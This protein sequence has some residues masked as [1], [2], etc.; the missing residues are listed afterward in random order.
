M[1]MMS[2]NSHFPL[3]AANSSLLG[4]MVYAD[5]AAGE[6]LVHR[7]RGSSVGNPTAL[8]VGSIL[9]RRTAG[10]GHHT[11]HSSSLANNE[12]LARLVSNALQ[13]AITLADTHKLTTGAQEG[14]GEEE[15]EHT[16][17]TN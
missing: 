15:K 14:G 4:T 13:E 3:S 8:L 1:M 16:L 10:R 9:S 2:T 7:R 5:A 17:A 12:R 6:D 11:L